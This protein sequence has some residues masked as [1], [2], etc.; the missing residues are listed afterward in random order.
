[1]GRTKAFIYN[2]LSAAS[3]Q[4]ATMLAGFIIPRYM[5]VYYG[6]EIN[7]LISSIMQFI[8]YFNLVEAGISGAAVYA[9]YK[10]LA[11]RDNS[12]ISTVVSAARKFYMQSGYIFVLLTVVLAA[13]Y[14]FFIRLST[15]TKG[16]IAILVILLGMNGCCE[17]FTLAKYRALLTADQKMYVISLASIL[18][19]VLNTLI[20]VVLA[21]IHTNI[22]ILRAAAAVVIFVRSFILMIYCRAKYPSLNY[23]APFPRN[24]LNK[25][26]D[27]L[28]LQILGV[29]HVS[30]PVMIITLIMKDLK[31]VSIYTIYHMVLGGVSGVLGIFISGLASSFGDVI[32]RGQLGVLQKAYQE[33]ECFYY[34]LISVAFGMTFV[35]IMPFI[36]LYTRG[37][38]DADYNLP[39]IGFLFTLNALM[40]SVKTPQGMLVISAG[41]Y[42]ETRWRTFTQ[43]AIM[44]GGGIALT[45]VMGIEGVLYA[46]I[47]SNLYRDIDLLFFI[48]RRLTKLPVKNTCR[49]LCTLFIN[50]CLIAAICEYIFNGEI[51]TYAQWALRAL[52]SICVAFAV[53][54]L[55]TLAADRKTLLG[56]LGRFKFAGGEK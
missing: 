41:M 47:V 18:Y 26:W 3:L 6:S 35:M 42:R 49:R 13:A 31:A 30:A 21:R 5:L 11:A 44:V 10:P 40:Y 9:L 1:M 54:L 4:I 29:I 53:V 27:A 20:V 37:V 43:G 46:S 50:V 48:P 17:F 55:V 7:G 2:S 16:E 8:A 36:N 22:V 52:C 15:L 32:A 23:F 24:I 33:F 14:P 12:T 38:T 56:L 25:R 28:F 51:Q 45:P 39:F 19:I 34:A